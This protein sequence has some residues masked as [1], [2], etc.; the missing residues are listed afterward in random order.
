MNPPDSPQ[1]HEER[2]SSVVSPGLS[3]WY[4]AIF[5]AHILIFAAVWVYFSLSRSGPYVL[6]YMAIVCELVQQNFMRDRQKLP[7]A[8]RIVWLWLGLVTVPLLVLLVIF[9]PSKVWPP[10]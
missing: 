5:P 6:T 10:H 4:R 2:N 7:W 9:G 3:L 8:R 1:S